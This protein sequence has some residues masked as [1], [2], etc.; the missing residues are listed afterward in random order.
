[1]P[2]ED[3][4]LLADLRRVAADLGKKTVGQ[5]EY[6]RL[7]TYEDTVMRRRFGSWNKAL[8]AAGLELTHKPN[9]SDERL[10]FRTSLIF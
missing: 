4:D 5:K 3:G 7:G 6:R 1:M 2:A 10:F 9:L 8:L